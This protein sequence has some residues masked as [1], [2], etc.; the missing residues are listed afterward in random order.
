MTDQT[1]VEPGKEQKPSA[2]E[3]SGALD[4]LDALLKEG[5]KPTE[6]TEP[7]DLRADLN[8]VVSYV[9]QQQAE[10]DAKAYQAD[11]SSAIK[12]LKDSVPEDQQSTYDDEVLEGF[13][14]AKANKDTRIRDAFLGRHK[15]PTAWETAQ[16][17]LAKDFSE[18]FKQAPDP[19]INEDREAVA[20]AARSSSTKPAEEEL[21]LKKV[22]SMSSEEFNK[23]QLSMGVKPY[24]H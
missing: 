21:T 6:P 7:T 8:D 22:T 15:N 14:H 2:S 3:P 5:E 17:Q 9:R 10:G 12:V 20:A 1:V 4:E 11:I 13:L 23:L 16:R 18:R 24:G 19:Q